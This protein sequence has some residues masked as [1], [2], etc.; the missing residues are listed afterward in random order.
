MRA[1]L[2]WSLCLALGALS[3]CVPP[4]QHGEVADLRRQIDAMG[5]QAERDR[6]TIHELENRVFLLEDK[7]DT[8]EVTLGRKPLPVVTKH[9]AGGAAPAPAPS[10]AVAPSPAPVPEQPYDAPITIGE[11]DPPPASDDLGPLPEGQADDGPVASLRIDGDDGV[12]SDATPPAAPRHQTVVVHEGVGDGGASDDSAAQADGEPLA[13]YRAAYAALGRRDHAAAIAGFRGFLARWP[14]H[15]YADNSQYWLAETYY[16]Q[17]DYKTAASEF[18]QV[19]RRYPG[20]NKAPDALLKVGYCAV[21]TGDLEHA[22]EI[23]GQVVEI[24]PKTNAARLA[25]RKLEELRK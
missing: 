10:P 18:R 2:T 4:A 15:D 1:Y 20:G 6:T 16:D 13:V 9:P 7:V 12:A 22:R 11:P 5:Q 3:G 19:L 8:T 21:K 23:L 24:Y 17:G 25:A 14:D